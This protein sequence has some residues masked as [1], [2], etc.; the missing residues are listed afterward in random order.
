MYVCVCVCVCM[1]VYVYVCICMLCVC[2][3]VCVCVCCFCLCCTFKIAREQ[4][5]V[6]NSNEKEEAYW[7]KQTERFNMMVK[8]C[9]RKRFCSCEVCNI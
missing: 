7:A 3:C 5:I 4:N 2:V 9:E 8:R 6:I 1:C